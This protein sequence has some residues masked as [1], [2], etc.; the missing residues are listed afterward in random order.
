MIAP[1][2][3]KDLDRRRRSR[4]G[5]SVANSVGPTER[6]PRALNDQR[7]YSQR[8]EVRDPVGCAAPA[9][10]RQRIAEDENAIQ[11]REA[12]PVITGRGE[13]GRDPTAH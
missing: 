6:V 7:G 3:G 2:H 9:R 13:L 8:F 11:P 1:L 5:Q 10:R 12:S 4:I